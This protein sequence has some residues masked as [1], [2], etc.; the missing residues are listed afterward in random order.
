MAAPKHNLTIDQGSDFVFDLVVSESGAIKDLTGYSA[1]S[2]IRSKRTSSTLA[3]EFLCEVVTPTVNGV[4]KMTLTNSTSS[5][6][7]PGLYYYDLEIYTAGNAIVKRILQ[8]EIIL[9]PEVTR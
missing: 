2:H 8:G 6:M 5:A 7:V 1:R 9:T 4:V 3:A